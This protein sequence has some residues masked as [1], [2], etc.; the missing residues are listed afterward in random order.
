MYCAYESLKKKT[1]DLIVRSCDCLQPDES[2]YT[3]AWS[4]D[5]ETCES[6]LVVAGLK[7]IIRVL[8]TSTVN[9]KA[10]S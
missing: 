3:C 5:S 4:Y 8:G 1:C 7:G 10:V 6:L 2:Y 9:C